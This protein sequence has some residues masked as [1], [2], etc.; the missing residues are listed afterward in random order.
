MPFD[1]IKNDGRLLY[2]Y[3]RG[4]HAH[5]IATELS[6]VDYGGVFHETKEH[7]FGLGL[8]YCQQV[9]DAKNDKVWYELKRYMLLLIKSNPTVL[10]SLFIPQGFVR[11]EHPV[12]SIV[13]NYKDEFLTKACF[14]SF[15]EYAKS[16]IEKAKG[17]NKMINWE[18]DKVTRKGI[19]DFTYTFYNQGSTKIEHWLEYRGLSQKYCGLVNIPNMRDIYGL[20]YDWGN[21][22]KHN[23]ITLGA[24]IDGAH[25]IGCL[26]TKK[27]VLEIKQEKDADKL[28]SLNESLRKSYISNMADFIITFYN[29]DCSSIDES[30][31]IWFNSQKE[32]GY[33]GLVGENSQSLRL[34]S[35]A[36]GEKPICYVSYNKDAYTKHCKDYKNYTDWKK[37][38]NEV[39]YASNLNKSYD[40]KNMC[41]CFRLI[42]NG[43]EIAN[44]QGYIVNRRGI[45]DAF[46]LDV[47]NHKYEYEELIELLQSMKEKMELAMKS[48][49]L[50][51]NVD[52]NLVNAIYIEMVKKLFKI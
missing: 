5:G 36:K 3:V 19:L 45:D 34:S 51:E 52:C 38:R 31:S 24:L 41:E 18:K 48:S 27:I 26:D 28:K 10:E 22:F 32:I 42:T 44:G 7:L 47:K 9:S 43:I 13:K 14:K 6:D 49:A 30:L 40:S 23:D 1:K 46:L 17:L 16:Q 4:S 35:V 21:F 8:D 20:Y 2:L 12:F 33:S 11:Y 29:L 50:K 15:Y 39:R 37:N 25:N